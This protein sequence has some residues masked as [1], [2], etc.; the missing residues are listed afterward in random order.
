V[1]LASHSLD[2]FQDVVAGLED[3]GRETLGLGVVRTVDFTKRAM[4]VETPVPEA[5]I[6][7]V[8]LGRHRVP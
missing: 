7:G 1:A 4:V 6:A 5:T 2:D 3:G 8:R